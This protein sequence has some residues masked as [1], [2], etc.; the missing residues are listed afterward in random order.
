M[1]G[2]LVQQTRPWARLTESPIVPLVCGGPFVGV[3]LPY[4]DGPHLYRMTIHVYGVSRTMI[5]LI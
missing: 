5:C 2:C 3:K 1:K 4:L